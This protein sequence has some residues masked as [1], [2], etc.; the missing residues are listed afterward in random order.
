MSCKCIMT[1]FL[2]LPFDSFAN[3]ILT[4]EFSEVCPCI[5]CRLTAL[6][7][8][9]RLV[10]CDLLLLQQSPWGHTLL[11]GVSVQNMAA[12][13]QRLQDA[14]NLTQHSS[15]FKVIAIDDGPHAKHALLGLAALQLMRQPSLPKLVGMRPSLS[16]CP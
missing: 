4:S 3:A 12:A 5:E 15:T 9:R 6:N 16:C 14:A 11:H 13:R 8:L 2:K 7:L 10:K 1:S